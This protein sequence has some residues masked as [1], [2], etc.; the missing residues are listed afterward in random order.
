MEEDWRKIGGGLE[1]DWRKVV[2]RSS[3]VGGRELEEGEYGGIEDW[4]IG[5]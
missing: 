5:D 1:E 4:R 3:G 2:G